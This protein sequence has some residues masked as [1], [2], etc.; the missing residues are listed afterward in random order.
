M[1]AVCA[2]PVLA[3][4]PRT[5]VVTGT[6]VDP[7]GAPLPG[8]TV[9]LFTE[10]GDMTAVSGEDGG[11]RFVFITPGEYTVRADLEGFQ[12]A[13]GLI[14]VSAG[15]RAAVE[16]QLGEA[17]GEEIVVTGETPL[18]NKYDVTAGGTMATEELTTIPKVNRVFLASLSVLPG[19]TND[20]Q[21]QRYWGFNPEV[22]GSG[23]GRN[24]FFIDGVDVS[25]PRQG[26]GTRMLLSAFATQ[27]VKLEATAA[28]A[29][30][31]RM[32]GGAVSTV[33][34][35]GT[36]QFHGEAVWY[37]RN[38]DWD[39]QY[40]VTPVLMPDDRK[41]SY[42]ISLAGPI[43]RD[44]L[45][46][47]VANSEANFPV[48]STLAGGDPYDASP[49]L[50][51]TVAKLDFRPST[52]HTLI[53]TYVESPFL[54]PGNQG[55]GAD[56]A[57]TWLADWSGEFYSLGWDW[58]ISDSLF[59]E[60][61]AA[62]Q[63]TITNR[64]ARYE[65]IEPGADPWR[66][67]GNNY[68]Y[69][70][71]LTRL[72]WNGGIGAIG[73]VEFPRDQLNASVN[74]FSGAHDVKAGIDYQEV[75]WRAD[76]NP[77]PTVVGRGYNPDLPGGFA[78]PLYY[79]YYYGTPEGDWSV[80]PTKNTALYV[81][82]RMSFNRWTFNLGLRY[83]S[84]QHENDVGDPTVDD[85]GVYPRLA[86]VFDVQG[87]GT[88][89]LSATA[90]QY[91]YQVTQD[92]SSN[93]NV[94]PSGDAAW[95]Q[96]G[97][98]PATQAYDIYQPQASVPPPEPGEVDTIGTSHKDEVTLGFDW[99][100]HRDWSFKAKA[101]YWEM[102]D[103]PTLYNQLDSQ[104]NLI[105]VAEENPY[106][107]TER[108]SFHLA[109]NRRF[110]NNWMVGGSYSYSS[111]EGTCF[112]TDLA[113]NGCD[114]TVGALIDIVDPETGIPLSL[115]NVDGNLPTDRPH[116]VKLRGMYLLPLGKRHSLNIGAYFSLQ[117]GTP[118]ARG[119][120]VTVLDGQAQIYVFQEPRG[121]NRT[122]SQKE[123]NLNVEWQ[124][125]I[126]KG[127]EGGLMVEALNVTNEQVLI[128]TLGLDVRGVPAANSANYQRPRQIRIQA[129]LT[130]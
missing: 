70:D 51:T 101:V 25:F 42:E 104:G 10:Q 112:L 120:L 105:R 121:S 49:T 96:Y 67:A 71:A 110:K 90:G 127:L 20:F 102:E 16:L 108:R 5:G 54:N 83:E 28:D 36:N 111:T 64:V 93:F 22:E 65:S 78:Q 118:W 40:D 50:E 107:T 77:R 113:T 85:S 76:E 58:A 35:S 126:F 122:P 123:L 7:D 92:W 91:M 68:V 38:L 17:M 109:V 12:S 13:E 130:F 103:T 32:I 128:G 117:D 34:R 75:E 19:I 14:A 95:D 81:R 63:N 33:L 26:G 100:F 4:A 57:T 21:S 18:V 48:A 72:L 27:E 61:R 119:G 24:N 9:Q 97:W 99:A 129:R 30:Y 46:F 43:V 23:G 66:P 37:A 89:L 6:V 94:T 62:S 125:P 124:F 60:T 69:S 44:K 73:D 55:R 84:Q 80:A 82:D 53:A 47:F 116:V 31:G 74:W 11:F 59:L 29:Q 79:R 115:L 15:G 2:V 52:N 41:D 3:D 86:A 106:A 8:A 98:N 88:M 39:E 56:L 87:D 45:W 114:P 1:L